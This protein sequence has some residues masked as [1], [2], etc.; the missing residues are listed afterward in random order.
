MFYVKRLTITIRSIPHGTA[1]LAGIGTG[2]IPQGIVFPPNRLVPAVHPAAHF[3]YVVPHLLEPI[4]Y[5]WS[6]AR[7]NADSPAIFHGTSPGIG[8]AAVLNA[9]LLSR[10][11]NG[12]LE[13]DQV[14]QYLHMPLRLHISPHDSECAPGCTVLGHKSGDYGMEGA[15]VRFQRIP[16]FGVKAE[17]ASA[18]LNAKTQAGR[19]FA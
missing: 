12:H 2:K 6:N 18:I 9:G 13:I 1:V 11:L 17:T 14:H 15:L 16:M 5:I 4:N 19:H 7:F 3:R 8:T 10:L